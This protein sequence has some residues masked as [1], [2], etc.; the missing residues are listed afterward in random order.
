MDKFKAIAPTGAPID[1]VLPIRVTHGSIN[2]GATMLTIPAGSV[3][4]DTLTVTSTSEFAVSAD[5]GR[6]PSLPNNHTGY[7]LVKSADLPLKITEGDNPDTFA[8]TMTVG[9]LGENSPYPTNRF[10]FNRPRSPFTPHGSLSRQTFNF[11]GVT[12]TV[13]ALYYDIDHNTREKYLF[14]QTS[15][16]LPRG[17]ELYLDSQQFNS[18]ACDYV[19]RR[20]DFGGWNAWRRNVDLNWSIGQTVQVKL[21]ETT[22]MPPGP[23]TNLQATTTDFKNVTLTWE[24]H[25]NT[26][27]MWVEEYELRISDD[28][29]TTWDRDWEYIVDS[30]SGEENRSS[31][32]I[33]RFGRVHVSYTFSNDTEYTFE[34]RAKGGDGYGDAARVTLVMDG[35]TPLNARHRCAMLLLPQ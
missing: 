12:Y 15:P 26:D 25:V 11:K 27:L 9:R 31:V 2:G 24:P 8:F 17:F 33:G 3:G 18:S 32:T 6:L 34:V 23:P 19:P 7:T 16:L 22:P 28:G 1:I 5:I 14:F 10:G 35:I 29:G 30:A 21:V 20:Q 13:T 4:S